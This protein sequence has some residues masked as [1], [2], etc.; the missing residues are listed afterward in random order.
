MR[1]TFE[2][3]LKIGRYWSG[4]GVIELCDPKGTFWADRSDSPMWGRIILRSAM[5][6]GGLESTTAAAAWLDEAG[7]DAFDLGTWEAVLRRLSLYKGRALITTTLYQTTGWLK[8]LY[9]KWHE[10]DPNIEVI[11]FDSTA[12]PGFS[13]EEFERARKDMQDWRFELF[14]RGRFVK[15]PGQIYTIEPHQIIPSFAIP[16]TWPRYLGVDFGAVNTA[17]LWLAYNERED[18]YYA[19][20][21]T[22]DGNKTTQEHVDDQLRFIVRKY[23]DEYGQE[24]EEALETFLAAFGGAPSEVQ[25]RLDWQSAG[26]P[27]YRPPIHDV[28]AGIDRVASLLKRDKIRFFKDSVPQTIKQLQEYSREMDD[29]GNIF[30]RIK[31]KQAQHFCDAVRYVASGVNG[32]GVSYGPGIY[33]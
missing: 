2:S 17:T 10:H 5:S 7:Q 21:E 25:Q 6:R 12:N 28:E 11:Q 27:V 20:R 16:R 1:E 14:Y 3:I 30:D 29:E 23:V 24:Q 15:L 22:L 13:K 18:R 26:L 8:I 9:D 32:A 19:Y 31:D 33:P 4:P